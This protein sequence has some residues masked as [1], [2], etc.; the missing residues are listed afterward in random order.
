MIWLGTTS[1]AASERDGRTLNSSPIDS[2]RIAHRVVK[3]FNWANGELKIMKN[4][5]VSRNYRWALAAAVMAVGSVGISAAQVDTSKDIERS[6][7]VYTGC[8]YTYQSKK[9]RDEQ[10]GSGGGTSKFIPAEGQHAASCGIKRSATVYTGCGYT[11]QSE[12]NR[13]EQ[14][15]NTGTTSKFIF[16][17]ANKSSCDIARSQTV[18]TGCGYTYQRKIDRDQQCGSGGTSKFIPAE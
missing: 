2:I 7:T 13:N 18:Y 8:V 4:N 5:V 10:C 17:D 15:G 14:C 3:E 11:Y 16:D 1:S 9:N 6:A 12:R